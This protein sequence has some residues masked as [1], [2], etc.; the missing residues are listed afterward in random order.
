M[1]RPR[2]LTQ[3]QIAAAALAVLDRDGLPSFS[4]RAVA[5]ELGMGTMSLYRYV[6]DRDELEALAVDLVLGSVPLAAEGSPRARVLAL[7]ERQRAAVAAH[8]ATIPLTVRHRQRSAATQRWGEAVLGALTEAGLTG[9]ERGLAFR[10]IIAY[11]IG[12]LHLEDQASLSG[13]GTDAL[14]ALRD[15][16][17]L[18]E[19]A[20]AV[21][22]TPDEREFAHGLAALLDGLGLNG[23]AT[24]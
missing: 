16:P 19:T 8:P 14:A 18:A 13:P 20:R 17:L 1:P 22:S 2:S 6:A 5:T 12:G 24:P 21:R 10:A 11:L 4:M 9:A 3:G 15:S 23:P 7:V